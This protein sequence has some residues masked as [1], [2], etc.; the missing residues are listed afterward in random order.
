MFYNLNVLLKKDN[1]DL[2]DKMARVKA[3]SAYGRG[4]GRC[5]SQKKG[6]VFAWQTLREAVVPLDQEGMLLFL[7]LL[8]KR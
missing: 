7:G 2:K 8:P 3:T 5:H 1:A 6:R 4:R